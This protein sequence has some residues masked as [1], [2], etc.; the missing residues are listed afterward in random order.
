MYTCPLLKCLFKITLNRYLKILSF[1]YRIHSRCKLNRKLHI[2]NLGYIPSVS[3]VE[4]RMSDIGDWY[5]NVPFFTKYWMTATV[6]FTLLGRFGFL[7][8][9]NLV[10][11]YEP[12]KRFQI[13]RLVTCVFYY[14]LSPQTGFHFLINLY[15]LYN[16]SKRLETG[17]FIL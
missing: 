9:Q 13:W 16:Y 4:T 12:L 14:P 17:K 11:L 1:L 3:V 10:L 2:S 15:F 8:P 6:G 7:R 5:R